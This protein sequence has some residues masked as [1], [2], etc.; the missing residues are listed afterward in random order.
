MAAARSKSPVQKDLMFFAMLSAGILSLIYLGLNLFGIGGDA[1]IF[2]LNN[3]PSAVLGVLLAGYSFYTWNKI[4]GKSS[5]KNLWLGLSIGWALWALAE[6][7]WAVA[8][9]ITAEIPYPSIADLFWVVGYP[10]MY[11]ALWLLFRSL[12]TAIG[13]RRWSFIVGISIL[14]VAWTAA[15][16][17]F[18]TLTNYDPALLLQSILNLLYPLVDL[19]L[20]VFSLWIFFAFQQGVYRKI[21]I[22]L[23]VGFLL[24]SIG[25]LLFSFAT[26]SNLYYPNGT[27]N[28]LSTVGVDVPYNLSFLAWGIGVL[29]FRTT[30]ATHLAYPGFEGALPAIPNIDLLVFTKGDD[31]V[32][33]F[34][35]NFKDVFA[36]ELEK[37]T[38]LDRLLGISVVQSGAI[39]A[40]MR[41]KNHLSD[42]LILVKTRFGPQQARLCGL[43]LRPPGGDYEGGIYLVRVMISRNAGGGGL[44]EYEQSILD[45]LKK[46]SGW[47]EP[48]DEDVKRFLE[49]YF[50]A[51]LKA[52]NNHALVNGG[53]HVA[54]ALILELRTLCQQHAWKVLVQAD[55]G[56]DTRASS[57]AETKIALPYLLESAKNYTAN[58]FDEQ[59]ISARIQ[60]VDSWFTPI[61]HENILTWLGKAES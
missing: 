9:L 27:T 11:V 21:W 28:L 12:P 31:T 23:S 22:W 49:A 19:V 41:R 25:N 37:N 20:L 58:L 55:G 2:N 17:L 46:L 59:T 54:E 53:G 47:K 39:G 33:H 13:W 32:T 26:N 14:T 50:S 15:F 38:R 44:D 24:H 4:G 52:L 29:L 51:Y 10:P 34:S 6:T 16:I 48:D 57:L 40:E 35:H 43:P 56:L 45:N 60:L 5:S 30:Q 7:W 1:F 8:S 3:T 36:A 18:P 42:R 61:E